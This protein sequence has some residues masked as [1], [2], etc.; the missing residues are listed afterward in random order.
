MKIYLASPF[1]NEKELENVKIA[2]KILTER[3]FSLFSPRL[4]EVRTDEI[5]QQYWWS[6][7]TFMNDKKFI[8]WADVVV[9]LYYGGYSDSGTAWECGYA[10]GT[11]TPVVVVQLGEDSNLMVHEGCHSN[12]TL[13]ELKTYDFE[14]LPAKP[15][16]GKMF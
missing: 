10:Y 4:N 8:D 13:E 9:M 12:I 16:K 11:N 2:E 14:M 15:Y 6:K 3:G 7:E 5:T 1:F